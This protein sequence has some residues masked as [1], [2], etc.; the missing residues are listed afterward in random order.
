VKR[1]SLSAR[2][3]LCHSFIRTNET[4]SG[5]MIRCEVYD[6]VEVDIPRVAYIAKHVRLLDFVMSLKRSIHH[7]VANHCRKH[8]GRLRRETVNVHPGR[9]RVRTA[10]KGRRTNLDI[11]SSR[12]DLGI[13]TRRKKL[14]EVAWYL[15]D[16]RTTA[17]GSRLTVIVKRPSGVR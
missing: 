14:G 6:V 13:S 4:V 15:C 5:R 10:Q 1:G 11:T 8:H 9:W 12:S 16:A 3:Y 2:P 7:E 17:R